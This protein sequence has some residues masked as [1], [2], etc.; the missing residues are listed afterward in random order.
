GDVVD[1]EILDADASLHLAPGDGRR[2]AGPRVGPHGIYRGEGAPPGVLVVVDV[3]AVAGPPRQR[4]HRG[5]QFRVVRRELG[6]DRLREGPDLLLGRTPDDRRVDVD[7]ARAGRL[8]VAR[9]LESIERLVDDERR[10][11]YLLE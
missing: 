5:H 3:D 7:P 10:L 1:P 11:A 2:D 4:V 9:H 8:G 6:G